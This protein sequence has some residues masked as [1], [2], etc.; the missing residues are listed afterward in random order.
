MDKNTFIRELKQAL[1]VLEE[2]EQSDIIGEYEQHIDMKVK[3]GL[4]EEEAI[5]DFGDLKKLAAEILAAYHVRA[6][7]AADGN[8][9]DEK[10]EN[11]GLRRKAAGL[12]SAAFFGLTLR[13]KKAGREGKEECSHA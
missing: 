9:G 7:Y 13:M 4:T 5:A 2:G 6:D 1:S 3:N 8:T 12:F 10:A 11:D